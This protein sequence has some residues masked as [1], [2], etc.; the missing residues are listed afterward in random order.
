ML[1]KNPR[2]LSSTLNKLLTMIISELKF[3]CRQGLKDGEGME[4]LT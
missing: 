3:L 4:D 2:I 1:V